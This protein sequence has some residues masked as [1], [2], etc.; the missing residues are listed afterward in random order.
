MAAD[1]SSAPAASTP[2]VGASA[3]AFASLIVAP[4]FDRSFAA[5]VTISG[6]AITYGI[7]RLQDDV[8]KKNP[9]A[10][11]DDVYD[12]LLAGVGV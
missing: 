9:I 7:A 11:K 4:M 3:T 6:I 12:Y 10:L 8:Q 2:E 5:A 1:T